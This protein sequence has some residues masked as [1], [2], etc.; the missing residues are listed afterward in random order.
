VDAGK[1]DRGAIAMELATIAGNLKELTVIHQDDPIAE[2]ACK[3]AANMTLHAADI[4][5]MSIDPEELAASLKAL[6]EHDIAPS[7]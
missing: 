1:P 2:R 4:L 3:E 5:L 7:P 6:T